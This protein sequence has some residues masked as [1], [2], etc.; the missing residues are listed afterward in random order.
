[1]NELQLLSGPSFG[2]FTQIQ[3]QRHP[4]LLRTFIFAWLLVGFGY[5]AFHLTANR[6]QPAEALRRTP[7]SIAKL[8][9]EEAAHRLDPVMEKAATAGANLR[10]AE[11]QITRALPVVEQDGLLVEKRR[12]ADALVVTETARRDLEQFRRDVELI[13]NKLIQNTLKEDNQK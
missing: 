1:M 9:L 3:P 13:Q 11:D 2:P 7:Q 12:L 10:R 8:S 4:R 6:R 5:V